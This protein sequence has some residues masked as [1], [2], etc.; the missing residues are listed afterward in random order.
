MA[1]THTH[2]Q[3]IFSIQNVCRVSIPFNSMEKSQKV[4]KEKKKG[5]KLAGD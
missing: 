2:T 1:N 3:Q 5:K 4:E